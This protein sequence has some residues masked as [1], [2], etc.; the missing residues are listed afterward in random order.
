MERPDRGSPIKGGLLSIAGMAGR[1]SLSAA[2]EQASTPCGRPKLRIAKIPA[3]DVRMR[4][5]SEITHPRAL[6]GNQRPRESQC[7]A[8]WIDT[9][10]RRENI[11]D[12][13]RC[14]LKENS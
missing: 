2:V 4:G 3:A 8:R 11:D 13:R 9:G 7:M 14:S 1:P 12:R 10:W 5:Y 6:F